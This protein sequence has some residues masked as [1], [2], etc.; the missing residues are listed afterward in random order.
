MAEAL[1]RRR[2]TLVLLPEI[3][4]TEPVL[5]R[6]AARARGRPGRRGRRAARR[7]RRG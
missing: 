1:R 4:L 2:L 3:A 7:R 6:F 5:K